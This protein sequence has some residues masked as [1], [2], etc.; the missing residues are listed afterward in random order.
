MDELLFGLACGEDDLRG[1]DD[2]HVITGVE[3][4]G[5]RGLVLAPKDVG[6]FGGEAAEDEAVG[7]DDMPGAFDLAALD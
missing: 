4:R 2:D 5:V 7:V 3:I 1:V 6:D